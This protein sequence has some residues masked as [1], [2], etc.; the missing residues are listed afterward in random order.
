[1]EAIAQAL[2]QVDGDL[3]NGQAAFKDALAGAV[4]ESMVGGSAA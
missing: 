3:S 2:E 1:M 4:D